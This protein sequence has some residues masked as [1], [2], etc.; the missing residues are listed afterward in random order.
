MACGSIWPCVQGVLEGSV[1]CAAAPFGQCVCTV[2]GDLGGAFT[3]PELLVR[4]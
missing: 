2:A 1:P 3:P 4:R